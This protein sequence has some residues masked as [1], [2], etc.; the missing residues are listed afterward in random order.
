MEDP[1]KELNSLKGTFIPD[2]TNPEEIFTILDELF[3][4]LDTNDFNPH[5]QKG[6][7]FPA[8]YIIAVMLYIILFSKHKLLIDTAGL[9]WNK[10]A[11]K[12][13]NVNFSATP[14]FH[15][16][17]HPAMLEQE[18]IGIQT[19]TGSRDAAVEYRK[20]YL[21][22]RQASTA[23]AKGIAFH[24]LV[25]YEKGMINVYP[26]LAH[27]R[28]LLLNDGVTMLC[29]PGL[30]DK[31]RTH[32]IAAISEN[33][34]ALSL[35]RDIFLGRLNIDSEKMIETRAFVTLAQ[36]LIDARDSSPDF[37]IPG[38]L[39]HVVD[40]YPYGFDTIDLPHGVIY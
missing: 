24:T 31:A 39:Q 36:F 28:P 16:I 19:L 26:Q 33:V 8:D 32:P 25:A 27:I 40:K 4:D 3:K 17:S 1:N 15:N 10:F 20:L 7:H 13:L 34:K 37:Q 35:L 5:E 6:G 30:L 22:F 29:H 18:V 9:L 21:K 12:S 2:S 11:D 38:D 14:I 23:I